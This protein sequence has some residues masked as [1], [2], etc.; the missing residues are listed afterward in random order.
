MQDDNREAVKKEDDAF[1]LD[2]GA[3]CSNALR[4]VTCM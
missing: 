2:F 4:A 3:L 1:H